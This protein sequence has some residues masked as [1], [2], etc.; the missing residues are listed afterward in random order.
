MKKGLFHDGD[1]R[2]CTRQTLVA[3]ADQVGF[4]SVPLDVKPDAEKVAA[5]N[6]TLIESFQVRV[7]SVCSM[8]CS[9]ILD[10]LQCFA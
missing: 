6:K 2:F 5:Y 9:I 3:E 1:A 8:G 10:N 7:F 4:G